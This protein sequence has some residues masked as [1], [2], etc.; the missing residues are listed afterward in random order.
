LKR[1]DGNEKDGMDTVPPDTVSQ[2]RKYTCWRY[3]GRSTVNTHNLHNPAQAWRISSVAYLRWGLPTTVAPS[4][5][6]FLY[7]A[8]G[9]SVNR[10][11]HVLF[12]PSGLSKFSLSI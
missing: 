4:H 8:D 2:I 11:H 1:P 10:I 9:I 5:V 12:F 3:S 7:L 6:Y